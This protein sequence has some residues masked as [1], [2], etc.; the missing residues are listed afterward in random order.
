M[1]EKPD[2]RPERADLKHERADLGPGAEMTDV[3]FERQIHVLRES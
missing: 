1:V 2:F 3:G